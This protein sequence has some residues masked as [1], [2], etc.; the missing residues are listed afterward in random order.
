MTDDTYG[1]LTPAWAALTDKAAELDATSI[2]SLFDA[3]PRRAE[4]A[5]VG[6]TSPS[7][8]LEYD[9]D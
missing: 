7:R 6:A 2:R 4:L 5:V 3:D 8:F 1:P 9:D